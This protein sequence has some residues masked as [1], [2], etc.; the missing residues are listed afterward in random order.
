[1]L[2]DGCCENAC[3]RG[4]VRMADKLLTSSGFICYDKRKINVNYLH[5]LLRKSLKYSS[6]TYFLKN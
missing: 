4:E 6:F 1:M 2:T 5:L 3:Y